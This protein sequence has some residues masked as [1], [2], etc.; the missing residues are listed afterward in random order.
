[1][2]QADIRKVKS[3]VDK[4]VG[5]TLELCFRIGADADGFATGLPGLFENRQ[6]VAGAAVGRNADDIKE[7][8]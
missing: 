6:Y 8:F 2:S 3:S 1:M 5:K 7:A 4:N